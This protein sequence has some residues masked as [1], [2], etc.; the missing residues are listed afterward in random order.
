M[1]SSDLRTREQRNPV[2]REIHVENDSK[3]GDEVIR[4]HIRQTLAACR[5]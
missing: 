5:T 2:I 1:C 4:R 3:V